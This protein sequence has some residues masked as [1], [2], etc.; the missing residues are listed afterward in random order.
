MTLRYVKT[1]LLVGPD[2]KS[3]DQWFSDLCFG[4]IAI[5]IKF[6]V[7]PSDGSFTFQCQNAGCTGRK[8]RTLPL[9]TANESIVVQWQCTCSCTVLSFSREF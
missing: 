8:V 6:H 2:E 4:Y 7:S 9:R 3:G 5:R 1:D